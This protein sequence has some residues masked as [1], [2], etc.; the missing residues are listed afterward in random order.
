MK[1]FPR[2]VEV[3]SMKERHVGIESELR[4]HHQ[5]QGVPGGLVEKVN[6]RGLLQSVGFDGGGREFRTN[7]ISIKSLYQVRGKKYLTEYFESLQPETDVVSTGGTHIHI[8]ILNDDHPNM[9]SNATALAMTFYEQFQKIAGRKTHWARRFGNGAYRTLD[10]V[11]TCIQRYKNNTDDRTYCLKGSILGPT[12]HQ[13]LEFRGPKGSNDPEEV[14]AWIEFLEAVVRAANRECID[15]IQFK[16]LVK[17][18]RI[19]EY[20]KKLPRSR[21]ITRNDLNKTVNIAALA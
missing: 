18:E 7:P 19:A 3:K 6:K 11:K 1:A 21:R 4:V 2:D 17:G 20:I 8:S 16:D 13:T 15:G 10:E 5:Y 9:E 12:R 14:L